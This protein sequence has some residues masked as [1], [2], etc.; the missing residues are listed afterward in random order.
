MAANA[1]RLNIAESTLSS[2]LHARVVPPWKTLERF[3]KMVRRHVGRELVWSSADLKELRE[4]ASQRPCDRCTGEQHRTCT[5]CGHRS[6]TCADGPTIGTAAGAENPG[7]HAVSADHGAESRPV[8]TDDSGASVLPVSLHQGDRQ[9][10]TAPTALEPGL[11]EAINYLRAGRD[12]DAHLVLAEAG[13]KLPAHRIP[14]VVM[15]CQ[16]R[17]FVVAADAMLHSAARRPSTEVLHIVRLFNSAQRY[18]E[19]DLVLKVAT[20]Q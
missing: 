7:S 1:K 5:I 14:D 16:D 20:S 10:T 18:Q 4:R 3:Y 8:G 11:E 2:Y 6:E 13:D 17:G 12:R 19:A 15:A 9:N